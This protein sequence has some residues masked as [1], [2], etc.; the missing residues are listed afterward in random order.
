MTQFIK[1]LIYIYPVRNTSTRE[2]EAHMF[3][4]IK[5]DNCGVL[6]NIK[7]FFLLVIFNHA[8]NTSNARKQL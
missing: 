5:I 4:I 6:K 1:N 2:R 3:F 8:V 7:Y